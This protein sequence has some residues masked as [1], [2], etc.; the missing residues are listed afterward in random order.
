[1]RS[2]YRFSLSRGMVTSNPASKVPGPKKSKPLPQFVKE[3]EMDELLEGNWG[4]EYIDVLARTIIMTFYETGMRLAELI[5][6]DDGCVDFVNRRLK[7]L[8]K[9]NKQRLIPFGDEL[10]RALRCYQEVRDSRGERQTEAFFV[11]KEGKRM[12][13]NQV[14]SLIHI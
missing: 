14:L 1:M 4:T 13:R 3:S 7:V 11:G 2:F 10:D 12:N 6:L 5:G 8:G 9:R